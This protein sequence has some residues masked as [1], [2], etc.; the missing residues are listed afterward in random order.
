MTTPED[1]LIAVF[2]EHSEVTPAEKIERRRSF[3][4]TGQVADSEGRHRGKEPERPRLARSLEQLRRRMSGMPEKQILS[5]LDELKKSGLSRFPDLE[6][7]VRQLEEFARWGWRW[8]KLQRDEQLDPVFRTWVRDLM[9]AP[10][11]EARVTVQ[12]F[13]FDPQ[14]SP[15]QLVCFQTCARQLKPHLPD[16]WEHARQL[17]DKLIEHKVAPVPSP[18]A[19]PESVETQ[20][21]PVWVFV[22]MAV[23]LYRVLCIMLASS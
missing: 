18:A 1:Y 13:L 5:E 17:L 11:G 2:E 14:T 21:V 3:L 22:I 10:P 8:R 12:N 20:R 9:L 23:I 19:E 16:D 15:E 4:Q 7:C 6:D